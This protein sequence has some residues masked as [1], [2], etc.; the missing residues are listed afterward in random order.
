MIEW[1]EEKVIETNIE[2]VWELFLDENIKRIM[3]KVEEHALIEKSEDE[4][5]AKHRQTYREGKRLETYIVDTLAYENKEGEK[6]KKVSFIIGKAF[7]I[8][9]SYHL[10]KLDD[11]RT[12]LIYEGQNQGVN[13]V[14]RAMLK[15]ANKKGNHDV[16]AEFMDRVEQEALRQQ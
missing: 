9:V 5:G 15:L 11:N 12:K 7:E 4:P 6:Y 1:K 2:N 10:I 13:F 3:P 8:T 16:V 14:G